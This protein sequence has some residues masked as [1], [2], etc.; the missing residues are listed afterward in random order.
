MADSND[1][2]IACHEELYNLVLQ[3]TG[4]PVVDAPVN[5]WLLY[6]H[7]GVLSHLLLHAYRFYCG[8]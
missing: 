3:S 7:N 6:Y 5:M 1:V 2:C 8:V 4:T